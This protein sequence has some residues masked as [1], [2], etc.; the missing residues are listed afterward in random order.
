M[1]LLN[2]R[3][4]RGSASALIVLLLV[5]LVFFGILSL[6]TAAA[7]KRLADRRANWVQTYYQADRAAVGVLADLR[8]AAFTRPAP[9]DAAKL[10]T[11][12]EKQLS[13][14]QDVEILSSEA[15]DRTAI[16]LFRVQSGQQSIEVGVTFKLPESANG[17][18]SLELTRWT[19]WQAPFDYE[20]TGGGIWKG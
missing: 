10:Q 7:D 18:V 6:V 16:I 3:S 15:I 13:V 8:R 11:L 5:L 12:L 9:S 20:N 4:R 19:S 2:I 14:R 17:L 1:K